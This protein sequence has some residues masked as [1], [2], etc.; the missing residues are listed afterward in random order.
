[1]GVQAAVDLFLSYF[2][3]SMGC[4][5]GLNLLKIFYLWNYEIRKCKL[6]FLLTYSFW[7]LI[8]SLDLIVYIAYQCLAIS[9]SLLTRLYYCFLTFYENGHFN[10]LVF[11]I[12]GLFL[13]SVNK[14]L[15]QE[16]ISRKMMN[17]F[18]IVDLAIQFKLN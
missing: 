5:K 8:L 4:F 9:S 16:V 15:Q 6:L 12:K 17:P 7:D 13:C 3:S 2:S 18:S 11:S 1:M 10:K 14:K